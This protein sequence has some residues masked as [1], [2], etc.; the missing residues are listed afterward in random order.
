MTAESEPELNISLG[1]GTGYSESI[2]KG[3]DDDTAAL[4]LFDIEYGNFIF[5]AWKRATPTTKLKR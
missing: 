4:P 5:L 2:Y 3:I 1:L